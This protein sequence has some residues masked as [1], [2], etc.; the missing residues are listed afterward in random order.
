M[1]VAG[2]FI[3]LYQPDVHGWIARAQRDV[4]AKTLKIQQEREFLERL[5]F[6]VLRPYAPALASPAPRLG[7]VRRIK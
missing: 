2:S 5:S 3:W 4:D 7:R 6:S 1:T